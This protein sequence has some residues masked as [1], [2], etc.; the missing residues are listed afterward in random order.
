MVPGRIKHARRVNERRTGVDCN[1]DTQRLRN[2]FFRRTM[3]ECRFGMDCDAA[4]AT[5]GDGDRE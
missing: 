1:G 3:A 5:Q 2:L 4:V